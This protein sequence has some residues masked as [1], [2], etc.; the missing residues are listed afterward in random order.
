MY[1]NAKVKPVENVP[2]IWGGGMK[3]SNRYGEFK[4]DIFDTL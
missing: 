4:D 3:E 1:V 2:G